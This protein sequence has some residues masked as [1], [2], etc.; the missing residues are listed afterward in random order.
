MVPEILGRV[1][2]VLIGQG[3]NDFSVVLTHKV[4]KDFRR[5]SVCHDNVS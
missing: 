3:D 4:K 1:N 5:P 2:G